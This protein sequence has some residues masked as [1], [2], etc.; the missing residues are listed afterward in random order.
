MG[1]WMW[2]KLPEPMLLVHL[3]TCSPR[4]AASPSLSASSAPW[5]EPAASTFW[6]PL[7]SMT[8]FPSLG[9]IA[10]QYFVGNSIQ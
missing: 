10:L 4:Q 1:M 6:G 9:D 2:D 7:I 8:K 5:R 3:P